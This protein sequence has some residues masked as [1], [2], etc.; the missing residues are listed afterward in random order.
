MPSAE[1]VQEAARQM[2]ICNACRYCEGYCAVFPAMELRR[3]FAAPD[4]T[5]LANLCFDC[6]DCYYACQYAPPHEFAVNVPRVFAELRADTYRDY[7]WPRLLAGLYRRSGLAGGLISAAS[8]AAVLFLVLVL[9]G[10]GVLLSAHVGPGAF[11]RVV[12]YAAM[13][14]PAVAISLFG[15]AALLGGAARFW[16]DTGGSLREMLDGRA[17]LRATADAFTLRY[18]GGGGAGCNYPDEGFS[19]ARRWLHHLVFYGFLLDL[20]ATTVAA[21]YDHLL[22]WPAPYPLLSAPVILGT[23]GGIMLVAGTV[24]LLVLKWRSDPAPAERRMVAMDVA[25]L[26]VLLLTSVTGLL[27]LALRETGA[28]GVLLAIH[29]G[30]VAAL[31]VTLPYGKF[32]HLVYRYAALIRSAIEQARA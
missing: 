19:Q 10:P 20:A 17:L 2:V 22:G 14:L 27:L 26:L 18:L 8:V 32:A 16:R 24:G 4:L 6:R 23:L 30:M 11:Y 29:L 1:L 28:M 5:Y 31:F 12:P 7:S 21:G 9:R 25:F 15:L 13:V 3:A